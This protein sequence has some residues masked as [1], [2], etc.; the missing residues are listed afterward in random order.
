MLLDNGM[1]SIQPLI[2]LANVEVYYDPIEQH[3]TEILEESR[4]FDKNKCSW[5]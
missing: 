3:Q 5:D 2:Y 1:L 4:C